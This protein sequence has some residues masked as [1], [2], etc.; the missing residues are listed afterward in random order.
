MELAKTN[1]NQ[2]EN[3]RVN[4]KDREFQIW[5]RNSLSVDLWSQPVFEQKLD[6]IHNNPIQEKWQL[7]QY[8]EDYKYSSAKY[9]YTGID[10]FGLLAH[11]AE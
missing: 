7:A 8:P 4:A 10:E 1:P 6:Y 11:Y 9:Y 5:E 3:F 2:L